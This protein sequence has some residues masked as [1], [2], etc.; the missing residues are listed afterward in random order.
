MGIDKVINIAKKFGIS[1]QIS[2]NMSIALGTSEV[3]LIEMVRAY[4]AFASSGYLPNEIVVRDIKDRNGEVVFKVEP[5]PENVVD[6]RSAFILE[7][8]MRGVVDRGTAQ[9]V[10]ELGRPVAGKTGTTN[11]HM[12]AWF[13]GYTPDLVAGVWV[14]FD[15]KR[16]LGKLETGGKA[17]APVFLNF[18]KEYLGDSPVMD[19][20]PPE[21]VSP[22]AVDV[23]SGNSRKCR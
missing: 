2:R 4:S 15:V 5:H 21:G 7:H 11:D 8:M 17:A 6:P 19:F 22:V 14:G 18:M 13:I 9:N 3:H 16:S 10:K 12:D 20:I 1:S 23:N